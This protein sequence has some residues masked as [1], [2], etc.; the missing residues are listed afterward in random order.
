MQIPH[1]KVYDFLEEIIIINFLN[2]VACSQNP[3]TS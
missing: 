2:E 3:L 1:P